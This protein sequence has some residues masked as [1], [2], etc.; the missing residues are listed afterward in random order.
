VQAFPS[1]HGVGTNGTLS[2]QTPLASHVPPK[3]PGQR[4]PAGA[5]V[6]IQHTGHEPATIKR[7][8]SG[9]YIPQFTPEQ[10]GTLISKGGKDQAL[11]NPTNA[12]TKIIDNNI[13]FIMQN[14]LILY[15]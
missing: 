11:A 5:L 8:E 2:M 13:F 10:S 12:I 4:V 15:L 1:S 3:G 7:Q 14:I 9:V 6:S